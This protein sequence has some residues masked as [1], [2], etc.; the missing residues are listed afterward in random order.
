MRAGTFGSVAPSRTFSGGQFARPSTAATPYS[1]NRPSDWN[2]GNGLNLR[3]GSGMDLHN[4]NGMEL[5]NGNLL[6]QHGD[7]NGRHDWDDYFNRGR[8][9]GYGGWGG[10]G[11]WPWFGGWD[12]GLDWGYPYDYGYYYPDVGDYYY[13]YAPTDYGDTGA[14]AGPV[15]AAPQLPLAT[16]PTAPT[17]PEGQPGAGEAVQFYSQ[18]RAAFL[19]GDYR[20]ALRL[21]G[22]AGVEAPR[23]SK[24]HELI[25]LALFALRDYTAAASEAH[26]AMALGAPADWNDLFGYY[27]DPQNYT[28]QLSALEVEKYTVQLRALE[29]A[30]TDDPKS[31]ADHFLL[32]YHYV[33]IGARANAKTEFAEA[34]KLTPND[35]LAAYYLQQLQSKAPLA[36]PQMPSKPQGSPL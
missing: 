15:G 35:K 5:H 8:Y 25:S 4:G 7:W 22:H 17:A 26:A 10:G 12:L 14:L 20:N 9:A 31:A 11:F 21:A 23:N 27:N 1:V 32:G 36:P 33:M 34:V 19:Q 28:P 13:S 24:V 6:G 30:S 16:T 18:A 2:A 29:K 3:N